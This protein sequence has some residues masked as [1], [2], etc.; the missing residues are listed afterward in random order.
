MSRIIPHSNQVGFL[1]IAQNTSSTDYLKLAYLQALSIKQTMPT[2]LYA[3]IVDSNTAQTLNEDY[4]KVFDY[5]ILI[6][7]D[8][9]ENEINKMSNEWQVFELSPFKETIKLESDL[10][11]TRD[12]SHWLHAFRLRD[13]VLSTGCRDYKQELS[14]NRAYRRLFD[15]NDLPDVY[16]GLMY[17]R[18]SK[19]AA[20]F[21]QIA[22]HLFINWKFIAEN[23]LKNV[24]TLEPSTDV[25]YA[26]AAKIIGVELCTI[27][28]MDFINFVHMKP[29]IN[30][31]PDDPWYEM[32]LNEIDAPMIRIGNVNQYHPVHY[33]EKS[34]VTDDLIKEYKN[35]FI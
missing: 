4:K 2:S 35:E 15:I 19:T 17:F 24:R 3:V 30:N 21:F 13:V 11:I 7:E 31:W 32:V 33:H 12:I 9:A 29:A 34:W 23:I 16:N 10:L 5:V 6:G 28:S 27:P 18:Y 14:S 22:K 25:V 8:Y 26:V 20:R 1:T